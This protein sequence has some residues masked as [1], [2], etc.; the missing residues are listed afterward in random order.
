MKFPGVLL[1][2]ICF[3]PIASLPAQKK[4]QLKGVIRDART[5]DALPGASIYTNIRPP[6]GTFS[7]DNGEFQLDIAGDYLD[8][9]NV[10]L[11]GYALYKFK[12]KDKAAPIVISLQQS[13]VLLND[14][15]INEKPIVAEEFVIN[16]LDYLAVVT[17][18]ASSADPLLA[19]RTLPSS[20]NQDES[21]S[22]SF[23]GSDPLQTGVILNGVPVYDGVKFAQLSGIGTFSIFNPQLIKSVLVFPSNPPLEYGNVGSGLIDLTTD[24]KTEKAYVQ[25]SV[26]LA[27]SGVVA[28][29]P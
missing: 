27:N 19:V 10:S 11:V 1:F 12:Y 8:S 25:T 17:N 3:A 23:R 4:T 16:R 13:R 22:I 29:I 24:S 6:V 5:G 20:S 14:V 15:E 7:A 28:G 26:G 21:A 9:I 2:L 18:P